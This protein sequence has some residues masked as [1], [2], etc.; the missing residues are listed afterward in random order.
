MTSNTRHVCTTEYSYLQ[1]DPQNMMLLEQHLACASAESVLL[2][3]ADETY[4]G[5][6]IFKAADTLI[7]EGKLLSA[8]KNAAD[9]RILEC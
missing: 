4:F 1:I 6:K 9:L 2:P 8:K 7:S 3:Q 5:P